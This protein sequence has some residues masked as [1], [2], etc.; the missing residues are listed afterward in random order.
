MPNR[1]PFSRCYRRSGFSLLEVLAAL[2]ILA[3]LLA[4]L[5]IAKGRATR[6]EELAQRRLRGIAAANALM[7]Q[8]W[9]TGGLPATGTS[10]MVP[11]DP[12]LVW[13]THVTAKAGNSVS[14]DSVR[15]EVTGGNDRQVLAHVDW[16]SAPTTPPSQ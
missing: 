12:E 13:S 3:T 5:L 14:F 10:G 7:E 8:W 16:W 4:G 1:Q 15:L 2:A 9:Q 11:G 6:Q